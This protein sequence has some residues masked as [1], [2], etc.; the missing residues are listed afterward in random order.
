M[1]T[2]KILEEQ[3]K[4]T[5]KEIEELK[6]QCKLKQIYLDAL[7]SQKRDLDEYERMGGT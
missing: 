4:K 3:I 2:R 6:E 5:E 7:Y 1:L